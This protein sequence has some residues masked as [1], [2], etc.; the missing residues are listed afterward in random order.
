M[1]HFDRKYTIIGNGGRT[2]AKEI[3][4]F[5]NINGYII[6]NAKSKYALQY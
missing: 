5:K 4:A 1:S 3:V 2:D 6:D